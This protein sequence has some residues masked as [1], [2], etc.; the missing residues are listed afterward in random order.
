MAKVLDAFLAIFF[1]EKLYKHSHEYSANLI[2]FKESVYG[3]D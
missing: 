1:N 2:N 3:I